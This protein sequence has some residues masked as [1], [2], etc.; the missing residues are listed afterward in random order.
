MLRLR[1]ARKRHLLPIEY[2][3]LGYVEAVKDLA[4]SVG[5]KMPEFEARTKKP[6]DGPDLYE[7]RSAPA[8]IIA[9]S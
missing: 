8:I 5:M 7:I 6:E 2:Q 1:R 9:I 3:G 4:E